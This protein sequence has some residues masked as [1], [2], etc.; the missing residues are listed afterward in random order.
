VLEDGM[1]NPESTSLADRLRHA[2]AFARAAG[3]LTLEAFDSRR[4][5]A[6]RK[7]DGSV[8]TATD[9]AAERLLREA[10][11]EAFPD[12]GVL[13]EELGETTGRSGYRWILD[14][15]DGTASFVNG[16]PLYG[17]LVAVEHA[18]RPVVGVV[19]LPAL[20]ETV[21]AAR[22]GGAWHQ[23][24]QA[25][26]TSATVSAVS[27]LD[28]ALLATTSLDYFAQAGLGDALPALAAR[29]GSTRGWS[30]CYAH[31]LL[32][33][34]RV[35]AVVEPVMNP[36]DLAAMTIVVEEAGG[37]CSDWEGRADPYPRRSIA[38]NG[39]VHDELLAVVAPWSGSRKR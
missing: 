32:A 12:D 9:R 5:R 23:R 31:A 17:T 27:A 7:A 6:E 11:V 15:I 36:W 22:G 20:D 25:D 19:H 28:E 39:A 18:G 24:G 35:D 4:V 10:I 34:G 33:T 3:D 37:R 21:Y 26:P 8:V 13:G 1:N 29:A 2:L 30:D 14:P 16:V 38:S